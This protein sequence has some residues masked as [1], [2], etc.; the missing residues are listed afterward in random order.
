MQGYG[1]RFLP[2]EDRRKWFWLL[3]GTNFFFWKTH[4]KKIQ[5]WE[6]QD[7]SAWTDGAFPETV[8]Q[9]VPHF[10]PTIPVLCELDGS[11]TVRT[12]RLSSTF[13]T[14]EISSL[15]S[16][17]AIIEITVWLQLKG[18]L[19]RISLAGPGRRPTKT[20]SA[21]KTTSSFELVL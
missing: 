20:T 2:G 4:L 9:T 15:I 5:E 6:I 14:R 17:A 12:I 3:R 10:C 16:T 7:V 21:D 1:I 13:P 11:G 8:I 18:M 19:G